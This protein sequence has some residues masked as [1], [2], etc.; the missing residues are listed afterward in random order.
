L[1]LCLRELKHHA[2]AETHL[3]RAL[4]LRPRSAEALN[5]LGS[6]LRELE[7]PEEA[8]AA[9][10]QALAIEPEDPAA[11]YNLGKLLLVPKTAAEADP[12]FDRAVAMRSG[13]SPMTTRRRPRTPIGKD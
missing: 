13:S 4:K 5:T 9:F 1:A 3:R 7:R 12:Y 10:R 2:D 6:V 8:E 11:N